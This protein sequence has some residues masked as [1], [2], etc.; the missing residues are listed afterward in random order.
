[1]I[2]VCDKLYSD[3]VV[4]FVVPNDTLLACLAINDEPASFTATSFGRS[5]WL[6]LLSGS[7][8]QSNCNQEGFNSLGII[9]IGILANEQND[10]NSPDSYVGVG[11]HLGCSFE[12]YSGSRGCHFGDGSAYHNLPADVSIFIH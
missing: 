12:T 5:K 10:C 6:S 2:F 9:R 3:D 7:R 4:R 11:S 8:I 1:M